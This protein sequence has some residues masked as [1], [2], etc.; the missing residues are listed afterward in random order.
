MRIR[1]RLLIV[2]V[3]ILV[4]ALLIVAAG[5]AGRSTTQKLAV[6]QVSELQTDVVTY[7]L[8]DLDR[9]LFTQQSIDVP[10]F[11]GS[12]FDH[13]PPLVLQSTR[14]NTT[15]TWTL[16]ALDVW[17]GVLTPE[18]RIE[19]EPQD[20][21]NVAMFRQEADDRWIYHDF[22]ANELYVTRAGG[23][24]SELREDVLGNSTFWSN[25]LTQRAVEVEGIVTI[26]DLESGTTDVIL[27]GARPQAR[28]WWSPDDRN[29]AV[30]SSIVSDEITWQV[31]DVKRRETVAE[32]KADELHWCDDRHLYYTADRGDGLYEALLYDLEAG[33]EE[34][35]FAR[36]LSD[37]PASERV[38]TLMPLRGQSCDWLQLFTASA[39]AQREN[40]ELVH[41]ESGKAIPFAG[42]SIQP[43][44]VADGALTYLVEDGR[45]TELRRIVLDPPTAGYEV[46]A[47]LDG[48]STSLTWID[49]A[50]G[51]VYL[52]YGQLRR[53]NPVTGREMLLPGV[54]IQTFSIMP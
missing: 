33:K 38:F 35:F 26:T 5:M 10:G 42:T 45:K 7:G 22:F 50:R 27:E 8:V 46:L 52:R 2:I 24:D 32:I 19:A 12:N 41:I 37:V 18:M 15:T 13:V 9:G 54:E 3:V 25:D 6:V 1:I 14:N 17:N 53:I 43:Y 49:D 30:S 16:N 48:L 21:L 4:S 40:V 34:V 20:R 23:I 39:T 31:I 51:A 28:M 36:D 47:S 29:L 44:I 11:G